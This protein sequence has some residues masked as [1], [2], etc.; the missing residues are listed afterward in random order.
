MV[1]VS[2]QEMRDASKEIRRTWS[3]GTKKFGG[4]KRVKRKGKTTFIDRR[5]PEF[6]FTPSHIK[7]KAKVWRSR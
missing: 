5:N 6:T 2:S 1:R 4:L 3:L 7:F